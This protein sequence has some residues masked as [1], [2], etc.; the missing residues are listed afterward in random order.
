[1]RPQHLLS[2]NPLC[3]HSV[4]LISLVIGPLEVL[5]P[6]SHTPGAMGLPSFAPVMNVLL[7]F[8]HCNETLSISSLEPLE[9]N[10]F[11]CNLYIRQ[12]R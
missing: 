6:L 3:K 8:P 9:I 12:K 1:M 4:L 10:Y 7:C 5:I 2:K 11:T